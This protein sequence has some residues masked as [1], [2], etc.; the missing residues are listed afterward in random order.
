MPEQKPLKDVAFSAA[1]EFAAPTDD[2]PRRF[3]GLAYGGGVIT[4]HPLFDRVAF[5]LASTKVATPLFALLEHDPMQ[6]AGIIQEAA[7]GDGIR[8]AGRMLGTPAAIEIVRDAG[9][10]APWQMSVRIKPGKVDQVPAGKSIALNGQTFSGPLTVFRNN[11]VRETSFCAMGADDTTSAQVFSIGRPDAPTTREAPSMDQ[12]EHDRIVAENA[13]ALAA[14]NAAIA[15]EKARADTLQTQF[16][17]LQEQIASD[18]K[19]RRTEAVKELFKAAGK[20]FTDDAARPYV[21]MPEASFAAV[22]AD[23]RARKPVD[24]SLLKSDNNGGGYA[25]DIN[26]TNDIVAAADTYQK[27]QRALGIE[28]RWSDAVSFVATPA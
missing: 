17:A 6:R 1:V 3:S 7:I 5:D 27:A 8:I 18:C 14:A 15:T 28:V 10:G 9:D 20:E 21:D 11:R 22:A 24:A 2:Q 26:N 13:T 12:A 16:S 25:L 19:A 4:D 23:M